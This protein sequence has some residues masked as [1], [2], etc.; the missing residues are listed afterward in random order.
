M[1]E[2]RHCKGKGTIKKRE[3]TK[4]KD[5]NVTIVETEETCGFC[6]GSGQRS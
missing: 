6:S 1:A 2:C 3:R 5:G 4:D